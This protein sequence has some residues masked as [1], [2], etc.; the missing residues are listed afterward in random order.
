MII[1]VFDCEGRTH[2]YFNA[3]KI[4]SLCFTIG[5]PSK[6]QYSLL[7]LENGTYIYAEASS[8]RQPGDKA[9][10][11]SD[12]IP[13]NTR[14]GNCL[15]FWY[16]M[17]GFHVGALNVYILTGGSVLGKPT[18]TRNGTQLNQWLKGMVFI[19]SVLSYNVS[20]QCLKEMKPSLQVENG[21]VRSR[22]ED[23][24]GGHGRAG[25]CREKKGVVR[26]ARNGS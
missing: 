26:R 14:P 22:R 18:W 20:K 13:P 16:H 7:P 19:P 8:P 4:S 3:S 9:V 17:Y 1:L 12:Q 23:T 21:E 25:K 5:F 10:L 24:W 6:F 15:T 11:V 2:T